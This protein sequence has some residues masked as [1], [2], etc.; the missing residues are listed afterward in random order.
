MLLV[1]PCSQSFGRRAWFYC[2]GLMNAKYTVKNQ[3]TL[4]PTVERFLTFCI[5]LTHKIYVAQVINW[6]GPCSYFRVRLREPRKHGYWTTDKTS[7]P[8]F[9]TR[10]N[11]SVSLATP[12]VQLFVCCSAMCVLYSRLHCLIYIS[13][14]PCKTIRYCYVILADMFARA[15]SFLANWHGCR[16]CVWCLLIHI[17]SYNDTVS[18]NKI[19]S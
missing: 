14:Q 10:Q 7:R 11:I 13:S 15:V 8:D 6:K 2:Y 16:S 1:N 5:G 19:V 12:A 3:S 17:V 9:R 4:L 18:Y